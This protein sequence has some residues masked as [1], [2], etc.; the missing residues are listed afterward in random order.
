M[1]SNG[2]RY[3]PPHL[4]STQGAAR[5]KPP[6]PEL[7]MDLIAQIELKRCVS[8]AIKN[9]LVK[10]DQ[11]YLIDRGWFDKFKTY[12]T[13]GKSD[14]FSDSESGSDTE[15]I[16][17]RI[18][19]PSCH[20][21]QI[22]LSGLYSNA[23]RD[24]KILLHSHEYIAIH[25]KGWKRL[26]EEFGMKAGQ[27]PIRRE[28]VNKRAPR[29]AEL[30][31]EVNLFKIE[32]SQNSDPVDIRKGLCSRNRTLGMLFNKPFALIAY[33][34]ISVYNSYQT[35]DIMEWMR[36]TFEVPD[37]VETRLWKRSGKDSF[38]RLRD[39]GK[40]VMGAGLES[41]LIARPLVVLEKK[42]D[43]K[44]ERRSEIDSIIEELKGEL[45]TKER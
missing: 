19:L 12:I 8:E 45:L 9:P 26:V 5:S 24:I 17:E 15:T 33:V 41:R 22:D 28:V 20:P 44:W 11:W 6:S 21:G 4:R 39:L 32:L 18:G 36:K 16:R 10:G 43:G 14:S 40:T 13:A 1:D 27:K 30:K 38:E 7:Q 23:K 2:K 35:G 29:E 34:I 42:I 3:V 37:D 31:V 25:E